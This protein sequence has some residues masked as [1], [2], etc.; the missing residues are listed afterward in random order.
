MGLTFR[1]VTDQEFAF[2]AMTAAD[3]QLYSALEHYQ[4]AQGVLKPVQLKIE[5][6]VVPKTLTLG[7]LKPAENMDS[8]LVFEVLYMKI[9]YDKT[10]RLEFDKFNKKYIVGG[11]DYLAEVR[12]VLNI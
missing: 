4:T 3:L 2:M 12:N 11:V 6:R 8:K 9:S 10:V 1:V 5:T 7:T